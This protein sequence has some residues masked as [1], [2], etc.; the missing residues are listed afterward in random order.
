MDKI[1]LSA[2]QEAE[3]RKDHPGWDPYELVAEV[4]KGF[5]NLDPAKNISFSSHEEFVEYFSKRILARASEMENDHA[6]V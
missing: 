3:I 6:K 2:A 4:R 5:E 1:T